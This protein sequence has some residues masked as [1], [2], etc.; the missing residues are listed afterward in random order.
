MNS[1]ALQKKIVDGK[2]FSHA[3]IGEW[4]CDDFRHPLGGGVEE[5]LLIAATD[6]QTIEYP[7]SEI[8]GHRIRN[9]GNG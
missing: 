5:R 4:P 9:W 7:A 2:L 8:A 6:A 3:P 1:Q